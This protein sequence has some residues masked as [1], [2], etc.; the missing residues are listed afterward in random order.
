MIPQQS[1]VL[2]HGDLWSGNVH[3]DSDG[4]PVLIDPAVY[5]GWAEA[6]LAM[7]ALFG[8]FSSYFYA[9][10]QEVRPL[11]SGWERRLELYNLWHLLNHLHLF[12]ESYLSDVKQVIKKYA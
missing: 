7:T 8:G 12:G 10:Y 6:D 5:Y 3:T 4:K 1:P 2:L 11:D 9:A